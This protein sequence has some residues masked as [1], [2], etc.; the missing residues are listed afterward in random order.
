MY[1]VRRTFRNFGQMMAPG[2]IVEPGAVKRF[3]SRLTEGHIIEVS[4]QDFDKWAEYFKVRLGVTLV[5]P[6]DQKPEGQKPEDQKSEDQKSEDQKPEDQKPEEAK[7][8]VAK[9]V[10][11]AK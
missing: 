5:K 3:K 11:T 10:V 1:V 6:E 2:S 8:S 7:V 4:E 9:V